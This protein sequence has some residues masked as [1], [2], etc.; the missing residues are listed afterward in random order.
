ML[1]ITRS[2]A[3]DAAVGDVDKEWTQFVFRTLVGHVAGVPETDLEWT[4]ADGDERDGT[5]RLESLAGE[6][7]RASV[8]VELE[9]DEATV[10]A[11]LERDL[12]RDLELFKACA[13]TRR[14]THA[15]THHSDITSRT[16]RAA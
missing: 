14:P 15:Q 5:V 16:G 3:V 11:H 10:T 13:E 6:R 9:G 1:E 12:E 7:T 8:T 2:I 4:P